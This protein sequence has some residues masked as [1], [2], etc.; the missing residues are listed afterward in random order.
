[1]LEYM[2]GFDFYEEAPDGSYT[3]LVAASVA[4]LLRHFTACAANIF[5]S[6]VL[7]RTGSALNIPNGANILQVLSQQ[8]RWIVGFAF[9]FKAGQISDAGGRLYELHAGSNGGNSTVL[10]KVLLNN[11]G[12]FSMYANTTLIA[13]SSA[14][15]LPNKRYYITFDV[16][17]SG[18]TNISVAADLWLD[19]LAGAGPVNIASGSALTGVNIVSTAAGTATASMH[20][21]SCGG[22]TGG[23]GIMDDWY[24][25][26][27][28]GAVNHDRLPGAPRVGVIHPN[29]DHGVAFTPSTA[30]THFSLVNEKP[31]DQDSTYVQDNVVGHK[32]IY[33]WQDVRSFTIPGIQLSTCVRKTDE[34]G[35]ALRAVCGLTGTEAQ[36]RNFYLSNNHR[37]YDWTL[38]LD[39]NGNIPWT[40]AGFNPKQFGQ[41]ITL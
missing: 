20:L 40:P 33:D 19:A 22:G 7:A 16:S 21:I 35:S 29:G 28:A 2:N 15:I 41:E 26:N 9:Y 6:P 5:V 36:S 18:T 1:M 23:L 37:W 39:P 30:G 13:T 17:F 34:G 10:W 25:F 24:V 11:D 3:A 27:G 12:T 38:D 31:E 14:A 8:A 32:D 4:S